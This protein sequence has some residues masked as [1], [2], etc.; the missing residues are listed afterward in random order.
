MESENNNSNN[1]NNNDNFDNLDAFNRWVANSDQ[2]Y[3]YDPTPFLVSSTSLDPSLPSTSSSEYQQA[4]QINTEIILPET[5]NINSNSSTQVLLPVNDPSHS[6]TTSVSAP[7]SSSLNSSSSF[8]SS[9]PS[10]VISSNAP[11]HSSSWLIPTD[12]KFQPFGKD[13]DMAKELSDYIANEICSDSDEF[14][15]ASAIRYDPNLYY[16]DYLE[17]NTRLSKIDID[18]VITGV[19]GN[20]PETL[21][22]IKLAQQDLENIIT[23]KSIVPEQ[24]FFLLPLHQKRLQFA[25]DFFNWDVELTKETL[26]Q[27]L[28]NAILNV[29]WKIPYKI[30]TLIDKDGK[31]SLEVSPAGVRYDLFSGLKR[32]QLPPLDPIYQVYLDK[33]SVM[34]GPF[35]SF[36]TTKRD[37][38]N[39]SRE[40]SLKTTSPDGV[41]PPALQ[42]VLLF[43]TRDEITEGSI[44]NIALFRDGGWKT[45]PLGTGC[46]CGVARH[47]LL[48]KQIIQEAIISKKS[49]QNG[50]PVLLFNGIQG[51]VRGVLVLE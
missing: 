28:Q 25:A 11:P 32:V 21:P 7:S 31:L 17:K 27:E 41:P 6:L 38:Y 14:Q 5:T 15:L 35:T 44:T 48:T 36:K 39:K 43:N 42:E 30:R 2:W 26:K 29:D 24:C 18:N 46:L 10:T 40:R 45:P 23:N 4:G 34:V 16:K 51:V 47:H 22:E 13:T 8:S 37:I 3:L 50:E 49:L 9:S 19:Q 12:D 20:Y 1:N 33:Q